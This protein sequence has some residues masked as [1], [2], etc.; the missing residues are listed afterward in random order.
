MG[1]KREVTEGGYQFLTTDEGLI[2]RTTIKPQRL[3]EDG[4]TFEEYK[5]RQKYVQD[6]LKQKKQGTWFWKSKKAP[7]QML[8]IGMMLNREKTQETEEYKEWLNCNMGTYNK[9]VL[10][11]IIAEHG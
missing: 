11:Q 6:Y 2:I 5:A 9:A 7:S 8:S 10:N 3:K 4:E 1:E